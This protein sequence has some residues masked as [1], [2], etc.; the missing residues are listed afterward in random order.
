[1]VVIAT[2]YQLIAEHLYKMGGEVSD[3]G[4]GSVGSL[5]TRREPISENRSSNRGAQGGPEEYNISIK[6]EQE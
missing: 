5:A 6:P 2:D 4:R 3:L 1:L